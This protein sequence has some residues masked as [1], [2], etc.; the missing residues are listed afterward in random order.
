MCGYQTTD[1][2]FMNRNCVAKRPKFVVSVHGEQTA[3]W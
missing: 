2:F 3:G 1:M